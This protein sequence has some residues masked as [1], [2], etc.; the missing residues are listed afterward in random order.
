MVSLRFGILREGVV[1]VQKIDPYLCIFLLDYSPWEGHARL[2]METFVGHLG[3][4]SC[5]F[6]GVLGTLGLH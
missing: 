4:L 5:L 2:K 6:F 1:C 3:E